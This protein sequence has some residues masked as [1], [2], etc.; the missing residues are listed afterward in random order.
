METKRRLWKLND[1]DQW[2]I[3]NQIE[4][5]DVQPTPQTTS[6][7][8]EAASPEKVGTKASSQL[9]YISKTK[10]EVKGTTIYTPKG[11]GIVQNVIPEKNIITVKI[12][13]EIIDFERSEVS[14][15][16][17]IEFI[18][19]QEGAKRS[20]KISF[21]IQS[22]VQDISDRI[23]S[24][25]DDPNLIAR[26]FFKGKELEPS[27][28]TLD[29]LGI[30]QGSKILVMA[31]LG[32]AYSV[33]R[34]KQMISG[35]AYGPAT[36]DGISF[37]PSKDIRVSGVGIYGPNL[38]NYTLSG[39]VKLVRGQLYGSG[40]DD[41]IA[42]TATVEVKFS[43][44]TSEKIQRVMFGKPIAVR[45]DEIWSLCADLS[46][47]CKNPGAFGFGGGS[48]YGNLGNT[49]IQGE[50]DVTFSFLPCSGSMKTTLT[51]V[52]SGQIPEI[53]YYT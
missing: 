37:S 46:L 36:F 16:I 39:T 32:K 19:V 6:T 2:E 41:E 25:Y 11:Y 51:N 34:F 42:A 12:N 15:D 50:G 24:Q 9:F 18:H 47:T 52:H 13:N 17:L 31:K 48:H 14:N 1:I 7:K 45:A 5:E 21:P 44:H 3:F 20:E 33:N 40:D 43:A 22:T 38:N 26:L 53:Y 23:S 30:I 49:T 8:K 4:E 28:D 10:Q 27:N 29:K 35:W